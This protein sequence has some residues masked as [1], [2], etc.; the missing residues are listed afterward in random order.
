[1]KTSI[2]HAAMPQR[3]LRPRTSD[4][5]RPSS[6]KQ[7][8]RRFL[9]LAVGAATLPAVSRIASAQTYPTRPITMI[10]P[11]PAGGG[12]DINGRVVAERMSSWLGRPIIIENI[13]GADGSIGTGR[14]ARA[15]PDGY[16][17]IVGQTSTFVLNGAVYSLQYDLLNDFAPVSPLAATPVFLFARKTLPANSLSELIAWVKA[18][19]A[20]AGI[21][22]VGS[23]LL[24]AFFQKEIGTQFTLVPYRGNAPAMQDLMAGHIDLAFAGGDSLP[25]MQAGNVKAYAVA[26]DTRVANAPDIPTFAEMGLPTLSYSEWF[27]LF[28]PKGTP[29]DIISRLNAAAVEALADPAVRSRIVEVGYDIFPRVQQTP[30]ALT[31]LVKGDTE[32]WSPLIKEFGIKAE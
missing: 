16:T 3:Q 10:V 6:A 8:R 27:G 26:S 5:K 20:S 13:S 21:Q 22:T 18:N 24:M 1:M 12:A 30:E 29:K 28:A 17:I 4:P 31:A 19:P 9:T 25:L 11:F 14:A 15:R 2:R 23:R 32:K 7:P